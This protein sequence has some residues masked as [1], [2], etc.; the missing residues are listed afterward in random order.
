MQNKS[1]SIK[2]ITFKYSEPGKKVTEVMKSITFDVMEG[3][4]TCIVG[5]SGCGK[6]TLLRMILDLLPVQTGSINKSFSHGAMVF[7]NF[8]LF[9]W[10]TVEE[11][12]GFGLKMRGIKAQAHKRI[13]HEK[14]AEVGLSGLGGRYPKELSGGQ[15]QR[16]GIA[17]A[18]AI[19]PDILILDEPFSSLDSITAETLKLDI[20]KIWEKYKMTVL[21]VTHLI[22]EAVE[23]ADKIIILSQ[24][25][26]SVKNEVTIDLTRPRNNRD[27]KFFM[28]VDTITAQ[29]DK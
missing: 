1:V 8:A 27:G 11:N 3:E 18:L 4:F 22:P 2:N 20:L 28:L 15:R 6:S 29:I 21:M 7:Q 19:N 13:V 10:L 23:L 12:V 14:L 5:P 17:R 16:V 24:K 25:P 9:P 26:S